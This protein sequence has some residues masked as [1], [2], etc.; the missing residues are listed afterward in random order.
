MSNNETHIVD[1]NSLKRIVLFEKSN[2]Y[3][4]IFPMLKRWY[5][6]QQTNQEVESIDE[7]IAINRTLQ[8][9]NITIEEFLIS[10]ILYKSKAK[11]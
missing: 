11:T 7:F 1:E 9:H 6:F 10:R 2:L 8:E 4:K 5:Y 3:V